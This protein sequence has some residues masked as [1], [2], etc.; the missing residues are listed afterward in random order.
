MKRTVLVLTQAGWELV[1]ASGRS[2]LPRMQWLFPGIEI[3]FRANRLWLQGKVNADLVIVGEGAPTIK[4]IR[5]S[6]ELRDEPKGKSSASAIFGGSLADDLPSLYL[7]NIVEL[8]SIT[9][10]PG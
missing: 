10:H 2:L 7:E 6:E 4:F 5:K 3:L 8:L 1:Q 9:K